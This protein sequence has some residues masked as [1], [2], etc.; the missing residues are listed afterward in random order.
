MDEIYNYLTFGIWDNDALG[1]FNY[2]RYHGFV[3]RI[4]EKE[5]G[6][7]YIGKKEFKNWKTYTSS[8]AVVNQLIKENGF[9]AFTF[10][11]IELYK[12]EKDMIIGERS[13]INKE[14]VL[15]EHLLI[16]LN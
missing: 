7:F 11:M 10:E 14:K 3:Y 1:Y 8:S 9:D 13:R 4:T 15:N 12:N 5:T 2:D 6:R 16:N